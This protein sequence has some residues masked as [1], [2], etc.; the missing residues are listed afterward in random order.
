MSDEV[1]PLSSIWV[2][3]IQC[4]RAGDTMAGPAMAQPPTDLRITLM[5]MLQAQRM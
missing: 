4:H 2:L 1:K 5:V 3:R